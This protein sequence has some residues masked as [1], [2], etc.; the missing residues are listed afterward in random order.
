[1]AQKINPDLQDKASQKRYA[2]EKGRYQKWT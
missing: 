1:M 2:F